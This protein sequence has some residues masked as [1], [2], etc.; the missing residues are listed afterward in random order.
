[1]WLFGPRPRRARGLRADRL[2]AFDKTGT[3]TSGKARVVNIETEGVASGEA[4]AL[5]AGLERHSEHGL[6]RAIGG[7]AADRGSRVGPRA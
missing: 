2:I 5:A 4:L 6:A 1:M 3:L 7:A